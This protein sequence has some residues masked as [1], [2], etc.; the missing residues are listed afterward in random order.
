MAVTISS[1]EIRDTS[2][3]GEVRLRGIQKLACYD[4]PGHARAVDDAANYPRR[5]IEGCDER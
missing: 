2:S 4:T 3:S 5:D 1:K